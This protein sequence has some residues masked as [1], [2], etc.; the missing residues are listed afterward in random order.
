MIISVIIVAAGSSK[1]MG[2]KANK[3]YINLKGLPVLCHSISSFFQNPR[4]KEIIIAIR[5]KDEKICCN[6]VKKYKYKNV[7]AVFGGK[8][9]QD[10]VFNGLKAVRKDCRI[11]LIH[12]AARPFA[13]KKLIGNLIEN[14]LK[15]RAVVPVIPVK[16]TVKKSSDG[17][18]I[19]ATL[20]RTKLFL[21]QTPQAFDY[22]LLLSA[23]RKA[24]SENISGTDDSMLVERLG[25]PVKIVPGEEGNIKITTK[26]DLE[27]SRGK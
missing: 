14:A 3:P 10:S 16:E 9:R 4:I 15:F 23:Y 25:V 26:S 12:D 13:S 18:F 27:R 24:Y 7:K 21:A 22:K 17:N 2:G 11:V 1:R 6:L 8:A 20:D 19:D 5:K